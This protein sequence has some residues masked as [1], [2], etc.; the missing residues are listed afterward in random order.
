[1]KKAI[2]S[3]CLLTVSFFTAFAE[4]ILIDGFYQ[5]ENLYVQNPFSNDANGYCV[6]EV[7]VN[8]QVTTDQ[9]ESSSFEIDLAP[10]NF[11]KGD[12]VKVSIKHKEG[13]KPQIL[14]LD[15][16]KSQS[17]F[18]ITSIAINN[19]G[20]LNWS[21]IEEQG[22]LPYYVE[23]Y[24]W[25]KWVNVGEV[26][27]MGSASR[28][29]YSFN[30]KEA[31]IS[32][33]HSG[34]N[35]YRVRQIDYRGRSR[36]SLETSYNPNIPEVE[37]TSGKKVSKEITFSDETSYELVNSSGRVIAKGF[38]SVINVESLEKGKYYLNFDA[39]NVNITI[40]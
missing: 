7:L 4:E 24:R 21:C 18:V 22:K 13:C 30:V 1:M 32:R 33:P 16:L 38:S 19:S 23:Q 6:Y 39:D 34:V 5:G 2:L 17:T 15:A 11:K 14:N 12:A 8:E 31:E 26:I 25:G 37:L 9:L 29:D 40:K 10:Y 36:Y 35:K 27:G 28:H 20:V 3:L